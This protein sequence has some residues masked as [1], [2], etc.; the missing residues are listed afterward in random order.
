MLCTVLTSEVNLNDLLQGCAQ[1]QLLPQERPRCRLRCLRHHVHDRLWSRPDL[2]LHAA[3]L[4]WPLMA[5][6]PRRGHVI[7]I[8]DHCRWPLACANNIRWRNLSED[9]ISVTAYIVCKLSHHLHVSVQ[10][11]LVRLL[12]LALRLEL[13]SL[14]PRRSGSRSKRS[15]TSR[16]PT[17]TPWSL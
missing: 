10:V 4:Q 7:L 11:L 8:L 1:G 16:S 5:F 3:Q 13:T 6:H 9:G 17:P 2:L 12:W 15:V 14:Q